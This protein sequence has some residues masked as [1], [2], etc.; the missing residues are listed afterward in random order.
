MSMEL[1]RISTTACDDPSRLADVVFVHG[2]MGDAYRTWR[3]S[4]DEASSW[5]HWVAEAY[6]NVG[7][8]SLGYPASLSKWS[9][10]PQWF[11]RH[12]LRKGDA[13]P[14][15]GHAMALERRAVNVLDRLLQRKLGRRPL[16][17]VCHS[18]GGLLVKQVL[19]ASAMA[20]DE[21]G[22]SI[23]AA[24]THVMFLATPHRGAVL[25]NLAKAMTILLRTTVV[26]DD[27]MAHGAH[28]QN[29]GEDYKTHARRY[30]FE[31]HVYYE[32]IGLGGSDILV[33]NSTS[34]DPGI[35][36]LPVP[37]DRD[38]GSI[39]K[40]REKDD[41]VCERLREILERIGKGTHAPDGEAG[42]KPRGTERKETSSSPPVAYDPLTLDPGVFI[43]RETQ[44]AQLR[45]TLL[46]E[47]GSALMPVVVE[48]MAGAGK[49]R[50][51]EEF[52][53]RHW[54]PAQGVTPE[55]ATT[56]HVLRLELTHDDVRDARAL[57]QRLA[58]D[59]K[60]PAGGDDLW[61][62]L[63]KALRSGPND[64]PRLLRVD[65]VDG[66]VQ[67]AAA[68][69]VARQLRGCAMVFTA[70]LHDWTGAGWV[71]ISA[72]PLPLPEAIRRHRCRCRRRSSFCRKKCARSIRSG[73]RL[74]P[75]PGCWPGSWAACRWPCISSPA[76]L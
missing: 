40:P 7:V 29:L 28:L 44:L 5:P 45:A 51:V 9:R 39:C 72:P 13:N 8:W 26:A 54:L 10:A 73:C 25:A 11:R 42:E 55:A 67:A 24:T 30:G 69:E 21:Q 70:R 38:H 53:R 31:T 4:E 37:L 6:A 20:R 58:E 16:I 46:P 59:M 1:H 19:H 36:R 27:L 35:G 57:G 74:K 50:L 23:V 64:R 41:P 71:R 43:G 32:D 76:I 52:L 60:E 66:P 48:G 47:S 33:V 2:L 3:H 61:G 34:A 18:L 68:A 17:F 15:A 75:Q 12:V 62:R 22:P 56:G 14:A 63:R 49:S 65:N